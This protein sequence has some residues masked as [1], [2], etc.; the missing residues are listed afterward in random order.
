MLLPSPRGARER[1]DRAGRPALTGRARPGGAPRGQDQ[2]CSPRPQAR[3]PGRRRAARGTPHRGWRARRCRAAPAAPAEAPAPP[4][5]TPAGRAV[6]RAGGSRCVRRRSSSSTG[7]G[8]ADLSSLEHATQP[9]E[10]ARDPARDRA[11]RDRELLTDRP[12]A[13]VAGKEAV[14]DLAAIGREL[15]Q[16]LPH[17]EG[18]VQ[19]RHA[20][21]S[22]VEE[23]LDVYGALPG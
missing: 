2:A 18:L 6:A 7:R 1:E 10:A 17:V 5:P 13:L 14:E 19:F 9:I 11:G 8:S 12:I 3:P 15:R 16:S 20:I 4:G 23:W 21:G 22:G